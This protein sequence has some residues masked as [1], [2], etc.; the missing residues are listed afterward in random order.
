MTVDRNAIIEEC[1]KT[2]RSAITCNGFQVRGF[3]EIIAEDVDK[4]LNALK[5]G[6]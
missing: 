2:A 3:E 1:R 5:D 4:A 6:Q